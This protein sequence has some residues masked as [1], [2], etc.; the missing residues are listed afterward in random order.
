MSSSACLRQSTPKPPAN[1][2][3]EEEARA[4]GLPALQLT[5]NECHTAV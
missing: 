3:T 4:P 2:E 1:R 5:P